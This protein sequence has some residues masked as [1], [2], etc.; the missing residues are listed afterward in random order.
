MNNAVLLSRIAANGTIC[1]PTI[2]PMD[3]A[4]KNKPKSPAFH[5]FSGV[6]NT[7]YGIIRYT[8]YE[9]IGCKNAINSAQNVIIFCRLR[10]NDTF[11]YFEGSVLS[12]SFN[13]LLSLSVV[14][15]LISFNSIEVSLDID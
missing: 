14:S 9:E 6:D 11:W 8:E 15:R 12:Y 4:E 3:I 10:L 2:S 7:K 1:D 13:I 5:P